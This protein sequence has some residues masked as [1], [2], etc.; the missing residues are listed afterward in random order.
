MSD[1]ETVIIIPARLKS[2]RF[3]NKMLAPLARKS[4]I[5]HSYLAACKVAGVKRVYVATDSKEIADNV[6]Q[7]G[8]EVIMTDEGLRNGT[9]RV[10]QALE[11]LKEKPDLVINFQGD[12]PLTPPWFAESLIEAALLD[13]KVDML[14]PV[15]R[16]SP[17][18]LASFRED[19]RNNRVGGTTA[20]FDNSGRALYF[21]KEVIPYGVE[22]DGELIEVYHHVGL[23]AYRSEALIRYIA[24]SQGRL[25]KLEGLEQLRFLENG[26]TVQ[27]VEVDAQGREFWEVNNPQD[28]G[29]VEKMIVKD[30]V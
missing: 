5:Q 26:M 11:K 28:I 14:T 15:V 17:Q 9:E 21:T 20:V 1:T 19:R 25:E 24:L 7:I 29:I 30:R 22:E 27:V 3:P 18:T 8:A 2:T 10:A 4:V 12:A 13:N 6:G 23:Y 16:C